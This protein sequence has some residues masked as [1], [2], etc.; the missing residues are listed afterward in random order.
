MSVAEMK[1]ILKQKIDKI[2]DDDFEKMFPEII[3][4]IDDRHPGKI[5]LHEL[6]PGIFKKYDAVMQKL[7]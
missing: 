1:D 3:R 5:N 4:L 6:A 7:A 2:S